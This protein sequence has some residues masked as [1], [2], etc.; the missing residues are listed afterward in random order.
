MCGGLLREIF[1]R[2]DRFLYIL[3]ICSMQTV[4][5]KMWVETP[6]FN[7]VEGGAVQMQIRQQLIRL[8]DESKLPC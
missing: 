8:S 1:H 6:P 4:H 7:N 5:Q 2:C 3:R